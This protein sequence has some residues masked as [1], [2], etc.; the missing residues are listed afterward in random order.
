M[1]NNF[2]IAKNEI[3]SDCNVNLQIRY[4]LSILFQK[5]SLQN[6]Y[7]VV[8]RKRDDKSTFNCYQNESLKKMV[9]YCFSD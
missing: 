9:S 8:K 2:L 5:L 7:S 4:G 6:L 1:A 3:Y